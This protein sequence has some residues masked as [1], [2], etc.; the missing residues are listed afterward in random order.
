LPSDICTTSEK[1]HNLPPDDAHTEV[2]VQFILSPVNSS[3]LVA[4]CVHL[5]AGTEHYGV[6]VST[7]PSYFGSSGNEY[8]VKTCSCVRFIMVLS[9]SSHVVP[10]FSLSI[11]VVVIASLRY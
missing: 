10:Y 7:H 6:V 5:V 8:Q 3:A 1:I 2:F 9:H 4:E 11:L